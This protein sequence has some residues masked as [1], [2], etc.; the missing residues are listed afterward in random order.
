VIIACSGIAKISPF[1]L[2]KRTSVP[3]AG[4]LITA[5]LLNYLLFMK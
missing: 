5:L 1:V 4:A 3:M 2:V